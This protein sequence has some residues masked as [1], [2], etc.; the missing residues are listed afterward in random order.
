MKKTIVPLTMLPPGNSGIVVDTESVGR[1]I[2]SR[3][4]DMGLHYGSE[5][6]VVS[7]T[8]LGPILIQVKDCTMAIGRGMARQI[9]VKRKV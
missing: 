4:S 8:G 9:L 7:S 1:G 3:L 5:I 2:I 6:K